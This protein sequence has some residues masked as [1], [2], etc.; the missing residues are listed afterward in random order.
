LRRWNRVR[1]GEKVK[2]G[3]RWS[4]VRKGEKVKGGRRWSRVRKGEKVKG[5][6]NRGGR[7]SDVQEDE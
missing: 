2:G 1:K 3:R 6:G 5:V 7:V 4:R